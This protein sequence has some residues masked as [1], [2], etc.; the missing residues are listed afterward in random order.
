MP[1][2][3]PLTIAPDRHLIPIIGENQETIAAAFGTDARAA[4][5]RAAAF[6]A[7]V[8]GQPAMRAA[9]ADALLALRLCKECLRA[10]IATERKAASPDSGLAIATYQARLKTA[11]RAEAK[12]RAAL[13]EITGDSTESEKH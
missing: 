3:A 9:V 11:T 12:L 6:V 7:A 8:N 2:R 5:R 13:A 10:A 4:R 1:G